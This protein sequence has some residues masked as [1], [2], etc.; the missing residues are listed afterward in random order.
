MT[1]ENVAH[2]AGYSGNSMI[3]HIEKGER[4]PSVDQVISLATALDIHPIYLLSPKKYTDEQV[5]M[6]LSFHT[7]LQAD[8]HPLYDAVKEIL[9]TVK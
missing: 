2:A 4:T 9:K 3:S 5:E 1:Q 6:V 7:L 8:N